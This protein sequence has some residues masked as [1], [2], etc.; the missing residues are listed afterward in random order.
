MSINRGEMFFKV[1]EFSVFIQKDARY[2]F[3]ESC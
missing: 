1:R 3:P 2:N